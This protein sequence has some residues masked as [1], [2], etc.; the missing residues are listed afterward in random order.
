MKKHKNRKKPSRP[1]YQVHRRPT[2]RKSP[3]SIW[4]APPPIADAPKSFR[5]KSNPE[6]SFPKSQ[7]SI[8]IN[9]GAE[10]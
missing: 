4:F 10:L 9:T 8:N 1:H 7:D 2:R 3:G 6:R 5:E